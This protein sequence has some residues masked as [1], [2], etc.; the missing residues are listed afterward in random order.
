MTYHVTPKSTEKQRE[1]GRKRGRGHKQIVMATEQQC[2]QSLGE[3]CSLF[4]YFILSLC[5]DRE[6]L[7]S[8]CTWVK[9]CIF[10]NTLWAIS[11]L[12]QGKESNLQPQHKQAGDG[13]SEME[14]ESVL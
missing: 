9:G 14:R 8:L 5:K 12:E 2:V 11:Q 3:L 6:E 4:L 1:G 10:S 13:E 7:G